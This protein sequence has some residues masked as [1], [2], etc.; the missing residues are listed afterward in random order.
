MISNLIKK[1]LSVIIAAAVLTGIAGCMKGGMSGYSNE[2]LYPENVQTVY[3]EMF[4]SQSFRRGYEY[5]L[6]DAICKRIESETPYKIVSDKNQADTVLSGY[7]SSIGHAVLA[8]ERYTGEPMEK[9]TTVTVIVNW[10]NLETGEMLVNNEVVYGSASY[11]EQLNPEQDFDYAAA[12]AVN[13]AAV[14]VVEKMQ[15]EW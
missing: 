4:D 12:A 6:T 8:E 15:K 14:R 13:R 7:I 1:F 9:E 11:S 3:V 10:K 5:D 2:W